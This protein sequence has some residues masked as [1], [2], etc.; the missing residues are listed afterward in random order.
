MKRP[1]L[2]PDVSVLGYEDNI[3]V[4]PVTVEVDRGIY[5]FILKTC[6][7]CRKSHGHGAGRFQKDDPADAQGH[8]LAHCIDVKPDNRGYILRIVDGEGA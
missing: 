6:P 8:R 4:V 7:Y 5:Q 3:P 1:T 2:L